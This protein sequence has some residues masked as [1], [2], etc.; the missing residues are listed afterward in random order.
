MHSLLKAAVSFGLSVFL[1]SL[2]GCTNSPAPASDTQDGLDQNQVS[3]EFPKPV[4]SET[5]NPR[6]T[7]RLPAGDAA[8]VVDHTSTDLSR[9]PDQWL[10]KAREQVTFI[11]GHTS[12]GSQLVSGAEYLRDY[13]DHNRYAL[14]VQWGE[15][16]GVA[17]PQALRLGDDDGWS[18][19]EG[20]FMETSRRYLDAN[21]DVN[22]FMWSW[23]GQLSEPET[24]VDKYLAMMEQLE[25]EYPQVRFIYMTGHTDGGSE[26]L[27]ANNERIRTFAR[28]HDKVLFDFA[29][30]ESWSPDGTF[31]P[32]ADDSCPWCKHWCAD[33]RDQCQHL[34]KFD[35][36]CAHSHG[37]NCRLKG[38]ALWWLA[39]RLAGWDGSSHPG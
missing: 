35:D 20:A 36:G 38:Q 5:A 28:S 2:I 32:T 30:I 39:A 17:E 23:C 3:T 24:D 37:F 1:L 22:A 7:L 26:T 25:S 9:I 16:P 27:A 34:P 21:P 33:H 8:I 4:A 13:V 6:P 18:W 10:A 12:H 15:L 19:D 11:Y 29:D 14:A 31:Y